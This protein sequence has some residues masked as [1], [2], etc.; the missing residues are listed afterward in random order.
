MKPTALLLFAPLVLAAADPDPIDFTPLFNGKDLEG[1]SG[2]GY[3]VEDGILV[4]T[5]EGKTLVSDRRYANYILDFGFRLPPAGNNGIGIH[6]PGEGEPDVTGI[7]SQILDNS[8]EKW[9]D[10]KPY[11]YHGSLYT[12]AAAEGAQLRPVGEWNYERLLV[13]GSLVRTG[14]NGGRI[15]DADLDALAREFPQ[16]EGVRRRSGQ[17]VLCGHGDRVEF[18]G[19]RIAELPPAANIQGVEEAGFTRLMND[20][21]LDGWKAAPGSE[22][23]WQVHNRILKFDG[24]DDA[25]GAVLW[26][27]RSFG[28]F[29]L[30]LDWRW[31]GI[32]EAVECPILNADG[33]DSGRRATVEGQD[34]G[35]SLRG[36]AKAEVNLWNWP[37]GSGELPG[38][39]S[40]ESQ[41]PE[42]RAAAT[43]KRKADRPLGEWNRMMITLEDGE[44]A[45]TLNGVVVIEGA[46]L[47]GIPEEGPIG[48]LQQGSAIDFANV[49]IKEL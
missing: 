36:D 4:C 3:E 20:T 32:G 18:R 31:S 44:L 45:V 8:A 24:S 34:S 38:V 14:L 37:V 2:D 5:T 39:R 15:L 13:L 10:L 48:L 19:L 22:E 49:W 27:E 6:Y 46:K 21:S 9:A 40:D 35:I 30:V 16:H 33:T 29:Q 43:P 12:L 11:Q 25:D 17:L 23:H 47:P 7:E 26:S 1:W 42:L 28:D 41:D